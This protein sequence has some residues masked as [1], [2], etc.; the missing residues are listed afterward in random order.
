MRFMMINLLLV[1]LLLFGIAYLAFGDTETILR[2]ATLSRP[3]VSTAQ[4]HD[5]SVHNFGE[6]NFSYLCSRIRLFWGDPDS[7][8]MQVNIDIIYGGNSDEM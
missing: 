8:S 1:C 3:V 5:P 6:F 2:S 4:D 7:I